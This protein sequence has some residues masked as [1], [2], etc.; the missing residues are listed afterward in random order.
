MRHATYLGFLQ[1]RRTDRGLSYRGP[2]RGPLRDADP[3]S[4]LDSLLPPAR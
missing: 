3:E 1:L 4:L 2:A